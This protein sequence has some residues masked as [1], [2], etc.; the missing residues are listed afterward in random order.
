MPRNPE[1]GHA[2]L[3]EGIKRWRARSREILVVVGWG[4][5]SV[6]RNCEEEAEESGQLDRQVRR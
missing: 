3:L 2:P 1:G 4:L 5:N 6:N